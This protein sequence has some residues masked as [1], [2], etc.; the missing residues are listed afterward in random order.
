MWTGPRSSKRSPQTDC[1][2]WT[3]T[4]VVALIAYADEAA[5]QAA[6]DQKAIQGYYVVAEDYATSGRVRLVYADRAPTG[7]AQRTFRDYLQAN[8]V[9]DLPV[10][11][12]RRLT[13]GADFV[14]PKADGGRQPMDFSLFINAFMPAILGFGFILTIFTTSGYLMQ[15]VVEEEEPHHGSADHLHVLRAVDCG[16]I[17]GIS[18]VG[19]TQVGGWALMIAG[20]LLWG[21]TRYEWLG[22]IQIS[23]EMI[24]MLVLVMLPAYLMFGSFMVAIGATV[25]E[26]SEGQQVTGFLTLPAMMPFWFVAVFLQNP[27]SPLAVG[28]SLFPLTAARGH[29]HPSGDGDAAGLAACLGVCHSDDQRGGG[30]VA[31][32]SGPLPWASFSMANGCPGDGCWAC[33]GK[34]PPHESQSAHCVAGDPQR[35]ITKFTQRFVLVCGLWHAGLW[36]A[37][38]CWGSTWSAVRPGMVDQL[39][40]AAATLPR[41][42]C[43]PERADHPRDSGHSAPQSDPGGGCPADPPGR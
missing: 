31:G 40:T 8:L 19:L 28:L 7:V 41:R 30:H 18:L 1:P 42:L 14:L 25:A 22:N 17:L 12:A 36:I 9:R 13:A 39:A 10:D 23:G 11:V 5:A 6:L 4:D 32:R 24:W 37:G 29:Q 20:G 33:S 43:G 21:R 15:A 26:A 16:Q 38:P 35:V 34:G 2:P 3:R 27:N